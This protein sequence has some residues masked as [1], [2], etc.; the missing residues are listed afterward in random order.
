VCVTGGAGFIGS[1]LAERLIERNVQVVIVD[2]FSIG[3]REFLAGV[4]RLPGVRI[5]D[6]DVFD[7]RTLELALEG[8]DWVFHLQANLDSSWGP[9]RP[10]RDLAQ[11]TI[12]TS[13]V[14]EAMRARGMRRI[15]F[16]STGSVYGEPRASPM[17]EDAPFPVQ[18]SLHAASKLACEALIG[19]YAA[20]HGF[21]GVICRFASVL[22]ERCTHGHVF[23]CYRALK[24]D[25]TRLHVRGDGHQEQAYLYVQDCVSALLTAAEHHEGD[26]GA[27]V[28]NL[29]NDETVLLDESVAIIAEHL[30]LS[31]EIQHTV[32][33][34]GLAGESPPIRLD[35]TRIRRLGWRPR[36]S[37]EQALV[38]TLA[39]FDANEYAWSEAPDTCVLA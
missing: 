23:D 35:T 39:W 30:S 14:L 9:D 29:G 17:T 11:N 34:H 1:S 16:T 3:R 13:C 26:A 36:L 15:L 32:G 28:Y 20:E 31:P 24:R 4:A 5:V 7:T 21:T 25:P 12:A 18:T 38:R 33:R 2:D 27:H 22:G 8:C 19:A 37:N 10:R 6:G